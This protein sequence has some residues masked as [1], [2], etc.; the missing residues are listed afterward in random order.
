MC[1]MVHNDNL[2][3]FRGKQEIPLQY[4]NLLLQNAIFEWELL[5]R[6][7]L[8]ESIDFKAKLNRWWCPQPQLPS[9]AAA[10]PSSVKFDNFIS[11]LSCKKWTLLPIIIKLTNFPWGIRQN[12]IANSTG[13]LVFFSYFP[14]ACFEFLKRFRH[15]VNIYIFPSSPG[16]QTRIQSLLVRK[17]ASFH[18]VHHHLRSNR[19]AL[20][21]KLQQIWNCKVSFWGII[22]IWLNSREDSFHQVFNFSLFHSRGFPSGEIWNNFN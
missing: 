20:R 14:S 18:P 6:L 10:F 5:R 13:L 12:F 15:A 11:K 3:C 17:F 8:P 16:C 21:S 4:N 22:Q 1:L 9:R 19:T 2:L 7:P